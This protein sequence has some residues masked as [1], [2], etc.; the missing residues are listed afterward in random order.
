MRTRRAAPRRRSGRLIRGGLLLGALIAACAALGADAER[1]TAAACPSNLKIGGTEPVF[2]QA[3]ARSRAIPFPFPDGPTTQDLLQ[4]TLRVTG[5]DCTTKTDGSIDIRAP[6]LGTAGAVKLTTLAGNTVTMTLSKDRATLSGGG[7]VRVNAGSNPAMLGAPVSVRNVRFCDLGLPGPPPP[8]S[9]A[10]GSAPPPGNADIDAQEVNCRT[11]AGIR[12]ENPGI[13]FAKQLGGLGVD[14]P[15]LKPA[16]LAVD[17]VEGGRVRGT[18]A[19]N[20]PR[21][22]HNDSSGAGVSRTGL[23]GDRV[24][25]VW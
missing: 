13:P 8:P 24:V 23:H 12:V 18:Y 11:F 16:V 15:K 17:D 6:R 22:L 7:T 4:G 1:A 3:A 9:G 14:V 5:S 2:A 25:W 20:L 21:P 10:A 19:V